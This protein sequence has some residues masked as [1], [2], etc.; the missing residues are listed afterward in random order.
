MK[1]PKSITARQATTEI[2]D[3]LGMNRAIARRDFLNGTAIAI[4]GALGA[5]NGFASDSSA[6]VSQSA[7]PQ[8]YPPLRSGLRG[9]YPAA[10]EIFEGLR[11]GKYA[12]TS[13]SD[14]PINEEYDLVIVGGGISGLSAAH[15]YRTAL[16][17]SQRILILDNHDD[18][19]GHA[20]RNEFHHEGRTFV[21][22]GGTWS[23][24]TPFPYSY[25]AKS[26]IKEL[27]I[28]VER[29]SEFVNRD[30]EEKYT[31]GSGTFFDKEHFGEDR[32]V[33]G[34]GRLPWK[35]FL[36]KSPLV[37]RRSQRPDSSPRQKS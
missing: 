32:L 22:F 28:E 6:P 9:Q 14:V 7:D 8:N 15:F 12:Q 31:L 4:T 33:A 11:S 10:A 26:L 35:T 19:G 21:G 13:L 3:R 37:R 18:F 29:Y 23:I 34:R 1:K 20:K 25:T 5:L 30:L 36:E 16:G 2:E 24:A 27:G 17:T